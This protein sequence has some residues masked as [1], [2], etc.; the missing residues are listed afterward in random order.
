MSFEYFTPKKG[1]LYCGDE[2][3]L[4]DGWDRFGTLRECMQKAWGAAMYSERR[5]WQRRLGLPIDIEK[6]SLCGAE[7]EITSQLRRRQ[8]SRSRNRSRSRSRS[9]SR[10]RSRS[11]NR[12]LS[13][14]RRKSRSRS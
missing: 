4:P 9:G 5:L 10:S 2:R 1:C 14:P 8:P 13:R 6:K 11:R 7:K 12:S 3:K